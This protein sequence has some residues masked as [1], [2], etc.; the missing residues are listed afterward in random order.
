MIETANTWII[1]YNRDLASG[2]LVLR[3]EPHR[4]IV[5]LNQNHGG[6]QE[7]GFYRQ[8]LDSETTEHVRRV[9]QQSGY[10][11]LP[12][13][14]SMPPGTSFV[15]VSERNAGEERKCRSFPL[16]DLPESLFAVNAA[17]DQLVEKI[18]QTPKRVLAGTATWEAPEFESGKSVSCI[19]TLRNIGTE[20]L[21]VANPA[22]AIDDSQLGLAWAIARNKPDD[23]M[24]PDDVAQV[25]L[26][27]RNVQPYVE[28]GDQPSD[29]ADT[30][31]LAAGA[32]YEI[33]ITREKFYWHPVI[34]RR[35]W[36][37]VALKAPSS[38]PRP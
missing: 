2:M 11:D 35:C 29:P 27:T 17:I 25:P 36:F 12:P 18:C 13:A 3:L 14:P 1:D 33:R 23:E 37:L 4:G 26:T 22:G 6:K 38:Q 16:A 30:V 32:E 21:E 9:I 5:V 28:P 24:A 19:L 34:T 15:K 7:M 8:L 31:V 10:H 20:S